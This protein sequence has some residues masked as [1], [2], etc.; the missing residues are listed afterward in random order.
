MNFRFNLSLFISG[1]FAS[2]ILA[3]PQERGSSL[4]KRQD[5]D[6]PLSGTSTGPTPTPTVSSVVSAA[7]R[8]PSDSRK[9]PDATVTANRAAMTPY[10][11]GCDST[12][13]PKVNQAWNEASML[14]DAHAKWKPPGWF[15]SGSYQAAMDMYLGTDS[16]NDDPWFGTGPLKQNIN[17]Q[18]GIHTTNEDWSPYWSY[19]Y[20]YCD[21]SK[22]P[23]KPNKPKDD[24][25]S[26]P[27]TPGKKVMAYTFPDDGSIFGWNA[28][29][30][31]LCPRFFDDEILT[32]EQQTNNAKQD[33]SIQQV[34][35]PWRKIKARSLFHETYHWGPAE[36][37]DPICNRSPEIYDAGKVAQLASS[38][39]VAGSKT[40]AESW[41][42]AAMACYV[43]QTF[44]LKTPPVPQ[45]Q[46]SLAIQMA[47][48]NVTDDIEE[49]FFDT[50]PD[51]FDSPVALDANAYAPSGVDTLD[52]GGSTTS[53]MSATSSSSSTMPST[54]TPPPTST[55]SS[56]SSSSVA[57]PTS[58]STP[59]MSSSQ[60]TTCT[61][62]L[63]ASNCSADDDQCLVD[64]CK[65]DTNC[66]QCG[67]NCDQYANL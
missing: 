2:T 62:N 58:T 20:I 8:E 33:K 27:N 65:N 55:S 23:A 5:P 47:V 46:A 51:W 14:A 24:E 66:Q 67:I 48:G 17:R 29:Y 28:K 52:V 34:M 60:C 54:E 37:S 61:N 21:E 13:K 44:N 7:T 31:V 26:R 49:K 56:S 3:A 11:Y 22:V 40:N 32:L 9:P 12:Q 42:Q 6:A 57:P 15:T 53:T 30:V 43:M 39:N 38:E 63:G 18:Q 1:F 50:A 45:S 41:A 36:V 64:Q 4:L 35:D 16:K 10:L 25:C 19:V 59:D